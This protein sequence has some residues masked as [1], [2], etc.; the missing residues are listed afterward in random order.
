[1]FFFP[2]EQ[3]KPCLECSTLQREGRRVRKA[4]NR[5]QEWNMMSVDRELRSD[6]SRPQTLCRG[7]SSESALCLHSRLMLPDDDLH[8]LF[9]NFLI[10]QTSPGFVM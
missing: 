8:I 1:M 5:R 2:Q 7:A 9:N 10:L 3:Q 4:R 6:R